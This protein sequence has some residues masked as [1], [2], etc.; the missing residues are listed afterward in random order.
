MNLTINSSLPYSLNAY[1]PSE[2]TNS[3]KSNKMD[4]D[5]LKVRENTKSDYQ[6][7]SNN[8]DKIVLKDNCEKGNNKTH[9]IDIKLSSSNAYKSDVYKTVIKFEAEQK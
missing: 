1:L 5:I 9:T 8:T 2:I 6:T 3:D 7:F 4:L